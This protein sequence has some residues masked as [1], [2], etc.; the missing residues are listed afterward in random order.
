MNCGGDLST[1]GDVHQH[2][3]PG[4]RAEIQA[5]RV[6]TPFHVILLACHSHLGTGLAREVSAHAARRPFDFRHTYRAKT[7]EVHQH[8]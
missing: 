8:L 7:L 2:R 4:F 6:P 3:T 5:N 1:I